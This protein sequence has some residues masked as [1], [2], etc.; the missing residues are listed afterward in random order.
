MVAQGKGL[1]AVHPVSFTARYLT[2]RKQKIQ[3]E[4]M[5]RTSCLVSVHSHG[6]ATSDVAY[7]SQL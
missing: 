4:L 3:V 2:Q 6:V 5:M 1:S 7:R